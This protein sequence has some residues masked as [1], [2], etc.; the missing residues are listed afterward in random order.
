M[1][2]GDEKKSWL[3]RVFGTCMALP[4]LFSIAGCGLNQAD[5]DLIQRSLRKADETKTS[6][7]KAENAAQRAENAA[8]RI[9]PLI[10][11]TS[12]AAR[13]AESAAV[14]AESAANRTADAA[15]RAAAAATK[16][17]RIFEKSLKK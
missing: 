5:R 4:L 10:S 2:Q 13:R 7:E 12:D 15:E 14:R 6:A 3:N 16:M 9:E 11:S 17:E 8:M 1:K